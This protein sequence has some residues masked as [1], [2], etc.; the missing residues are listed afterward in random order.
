MIT[1]YLDTNIISFLH[2]PEDYPK[3]PWQLDAPLITSFLEKNADVRPLYSPA[4]LMDVR[5]GYVKDQQRAIE[6]LR[7]IGSITHN[8]RLTNTWATI[9]LL[10]KK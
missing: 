5:K 3:Q 6:K 7:F 4:H 10:L 9:K 2:H 1:V 8:S